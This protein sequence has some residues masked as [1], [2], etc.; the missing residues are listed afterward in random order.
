MVS[1]DR[2]SFSNLQL[3]IRVFLI[4]QIHFYS[5][6]YG[7]SDQPHHVAFNQ[8]S[9]RRSTLFEFG[10]YLTRIRPL[11]QL[12]VVSGAIVVLVWI[13][14]AFSVKP[15]LWICTSTVVIYLLW[16]GNGGIV[17]A[18]TWVTVL[19]VLAIVADVRPDIWQ[20]VRPYRMWARIL[21]SLWLTGT[22]TVFFLGQQGELCSSY[23]GKLC[24]QLRLISVASALVGGCMGKLLFDVGG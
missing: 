5:Q 1:I 22:G 4:V 11:L 24:I 16:T 20:G 15:L 17:P 14:C 9:L 7:R 21:G 18:V 23:P 6:H 10:A 19:I 8:H 12:P 3:K 2:C 13:G